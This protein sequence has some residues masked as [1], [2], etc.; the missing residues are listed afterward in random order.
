MGCQL[1]ISLNGLHNLQTSLT[2]AS[3]MAVG[4]KAKAARPLQAQ[5]LNLAH[6]FFHMPLGKKHC[7]KLYKSKSQAQPSLK[8]QGNRFQLWMRS[9]KLS[10]QYF[11]IYHI[12][13]GRGSYDPES[14]VWNSNSQCWP[15]QSH[16]ICHPQIHHFGIGIILAT[17]KQQIQEKLP[18]LPLYA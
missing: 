17:E 15:L 13:R 14:L 5:T 8:K 10:R 11:L 1:A 12:N 3:T 16:R 2:G 6:Y 9:C 7:A 4:E 18:A